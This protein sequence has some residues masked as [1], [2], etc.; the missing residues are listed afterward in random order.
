MEIEQGSV[1]GYKEPGQKYYGFF[2]IPYATA[3]TGQHKFKAPLPAPRWHDVLEA[4]NRYILCPQNP[5]LIPLLRDNKNFI[6]T[7][8]CLNVNIYV[9]YTKETN[10]PV[11]VYLH[12]GAF[13]IGFGDMLRHTPLVE[14]SK[15]IV[16]NFNYRLGAHG[17]LCL[18]TKDVPGNAGLKDQVAALRWVKNN[19]VKFGGNSDD[20]TLAGYSGGSVAANLL[21]LSEAARGLFNKVISESGPPNTVWG[22]QSDPIANAKQFALANNFENVDDPVALEKF[23]KTT[24]LDVLLADTFFVTKDTS[25]TFVPCVEKPGSKE[26]IINDAP[27]NLFIKG[28]FNKVPVFIG[29][30]NNEGMFRLPVFDL[31]SKEM[32][33]KFAEFLPGDLQFA[34]IEERNKVSEVIKEFYFDSKEINEKTVEGYV[35]YF[36]DSIYASPIM[37]FVQLYLEKGG[38]S[39]YLYNYSY[40]DKNQYYLHNFKGTNHAAQSATISVNA[41]EDDVEELSEE[42]GNLRRNHVQIWTNFI[43]TGKPVSENSSLFPSGWPQTT[44]ENQAYM[45]LNVMPKLRHDLLKERMEFWED[46]YRNY[47]R[48]PVSP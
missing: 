42:Y 20:V 4:T 25:M 34:N 47:Y 44:L 41:L 28:K 30:A 29:L 5:M 19:I 35:N 15:V 12:G 32:N 33:N 14:T 16:V 46:I 48:T 8:N 37:R 11:V 45:E 21:I 10:L 23:Y 3:P 17:F 40:I 13:Q 2:G 6:I 1:R 22:I 9:P 43:T 27:M 39:V 7:E 31:W 26:S 18:G 24:S 36:T 38:S